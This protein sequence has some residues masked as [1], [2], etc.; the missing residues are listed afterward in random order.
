MA[1][2]SEDEPVVS[3]NMEPGDSYSKTFNMTGLLDYHCHPHPWMLAQIEVTESSGRAP[4]NWTVAATEPEGQEFE[5]WAW[6]PSTLIIEVGDT[7]TWINN[8][9]V[10]H[11]VQETTA[12]HKDHVGT[13]DGDHLGPGGH[14]ADAHA[15]DDSAAHAHGAEEIPWYGIP[16]LFSA[17]VVVGL[18]WWDSRRKP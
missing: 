1:S 18:V 17:V 8:G 16:I 14:A 2:A 10:M 5:H 6:N 4:M 15:D 7:V 9:T 3:P 13:V 11:K 12:E